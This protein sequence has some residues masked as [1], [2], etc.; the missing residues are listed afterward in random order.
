MK[1]NQIELVQAICK[2]LEK[3][4]FQPTMLHLNAIIKASLDI[5]SECERVPVMATEGMGLVAWLQCDDTGLSSCYMAS[6]LDGRFCREYA[7]PH[8]LDDF[9]RC[10]R[11]LKA[12]P[13]FRLRVSKMAV[14]SQQWAK[15]VA[16]WSEIET[17]ATTRPKEANK[18]I[19]E[20][21]AE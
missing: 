15:L 17:T 10:V 12:V 6:V 20:T 18:L 16:R 9:M 5:I 2:H 14:K 1:I 13:E 19:W 8:D 4:E 7:H 3:Q 21:L 11:L